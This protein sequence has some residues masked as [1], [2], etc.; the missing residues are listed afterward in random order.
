MT[1]TLDESRAIAATEARIALL[2]IENERRLK[3]IQALTENLS[4][5]VSNLQKVVDY[6]S[7]TGGVIQPPVRGVMI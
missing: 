7:S 3:E 4:L 5:A 1:L 2:E 6:L